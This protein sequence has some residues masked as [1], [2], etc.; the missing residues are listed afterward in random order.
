M[1]PETTADRA[2]LLALLGQRV[3]TLLVDTVLNMPA[4]DY[5]PLWADNSIDLI[6][7]SPPY[8]N[9]REYKGFTW[10]FERIARECYRVLKPGGVLVWIVGDAT[11]DG[12]ETLTSMRQALYFVDAVGFKM[13][14]TMI[15]QK[16]GLA[17]PDSN[18]YY[19][20]FEY[21]FIL[22]KGVPKTVNLL[23]DRVNVSAGRG[24]NGMDRNRDGSFKPRT[25]TGHILAKYG[26]R[27]NIWLISNGER[28]TRHP[29]PFPENLAHDHIVSWTNPGDVVL[30][31]F[32][33]S[34]TTA[35]MARNLKRHYAGCELAAEYMPIIHDRLRLP[36][37]PRQVRVEETYDDL[38]LFAQVAGE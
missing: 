14:D 26:I 13:H 7:T 37:E 23:V 29:A 15:Y 19:Q 21:M 4:E 12:C 3:H 35:K 24:V 5:L 22:S 9:L 27:F 31:C 1:P 10:D 18:R 6:L 38:P 32:M 28:L 17:Y 36:F 20:M 2:A 33:G 8:D 25:G 11:V 34:G 16:T 30:D